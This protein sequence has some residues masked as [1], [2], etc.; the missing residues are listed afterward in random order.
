MADGS[1]S[2]FDRWRIRKSYGEERDRRPSVVINH[3][4][5]LAN[6]TDCVYLNRAYLCWRSVQAFR[7]IRNLSRRVRHLLTLLALS[8]SL[9]GLLQ[10]FSLA[11][12]AFHCHKLLHNL[13]RRSGPSGLDSKNLTILI[14]D[15]NTP[16]SSLWRFL[17]PNSLDETRARVTEERV[18]QFLLGFECSVGL[19]TVGAETVDRET[20]GRQ[21]CVRVSEKADLGRAAAGGCMLVGVLLR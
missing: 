6:R 9:L 17:E 15:K 8:S 18:R 10:P 3:C 21:R 19:W 14:N 7:H 2:T 12:T 20:G 11:I 13:N 5:Y 4:I 1:I 16:L